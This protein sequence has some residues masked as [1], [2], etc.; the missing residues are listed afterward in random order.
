MWC[1]KSEVTEDYNELKN[2]RKELPSEF[3]I[4]SDCIVFRVVSVHACKDHVI[5]ASSVF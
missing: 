4:F 3:H 2:K 5:L 1:I